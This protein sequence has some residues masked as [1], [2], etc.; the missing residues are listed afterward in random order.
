MSVMSQVFELSV[1]A[2][3]QIARRAVKTFSE[4]IIE[5]QKD[6]DFGKDIPKWMLFFWKKNKTI[7]YIVCWTFNSHI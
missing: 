3:I 6:E 1:D 4:C 5:N 2:K 7:M